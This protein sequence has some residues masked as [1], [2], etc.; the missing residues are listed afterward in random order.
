MPNDTRSNAVALGIIGVVLFLG[1]AALLVSL[2]GQGR[3]TN[4][5]LMDSTK[6][7]FIAHGVMTAH[8]DRLTIRHD[9]EQ[10][11]DAGILDTW[12]L[13]PGTS[14]AD[15]PPQGEEPFEEYGETW[16]LWGEAY[17]DDDPEVWNSESNVIAVVLRFPDGDWGFATSLGEAQEGADPTDV[18][19]RMRTERAETGFSRVP[20]PLVEALTSGK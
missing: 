4:P 15:L 12:V 1:A 16:V 17:I 3:R 20:E 11:L 10:L 13:M 5:Q 14:G 9:R 8:F 19:D 18:L 6:L 2:D 7:R